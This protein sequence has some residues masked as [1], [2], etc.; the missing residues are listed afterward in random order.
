MLDPVI[1]PRKAEDDCAVI[2]GCCNGPIAISRRDLPGYCVGAGS[3]L[4][5]ALCVLALGYLVI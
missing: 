4:L 5:V 1:Q 2:V 3:V